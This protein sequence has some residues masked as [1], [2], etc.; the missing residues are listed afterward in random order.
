MKTALWFLTAALVSS[1]ALA[2]EK[3]KQ[4]ATAHKAAPAKDK[5]PPELADFPKQPKRL[6]SERY[7]EPGAPTDYTKPD[8]RHSPR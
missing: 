2:A 5:T 6:S 3:P 8:P 4:N 7:A 1:G